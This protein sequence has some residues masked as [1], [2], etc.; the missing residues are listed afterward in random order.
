MSDGKLKL[1][2]SQ[3]CSTRHTSFLI[4]FLYIS[5]L[6]QITSLKLESSS[7]MNEIKASDSNNL[8]NGS[9]LQYNILD[10]KYYLNKIYQSQINLIIKII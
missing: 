4:C 2:F 9:S 10:C 1:Y 6:D 8:S 3:T 7:N 5:K